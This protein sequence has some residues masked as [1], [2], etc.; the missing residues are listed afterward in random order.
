ME[1]FSQPKLSIYTTGQKTSSNFW[2]AHCPKATMI[3]LIKPANSDNMD[4]CIQP[5][6]ETEVAAALKCIKNGHSPG[7]CSITAKLLKVGGWVLPTGSPISLMKSGSEKN[8]QV[9]GDVV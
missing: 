3:F 4:I 9:T 5:V 8:F 6:A 2:I 1:M 7:I